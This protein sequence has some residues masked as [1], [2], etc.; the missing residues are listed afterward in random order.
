MFYKGLHWLL[1]IKQ[2]FTRFGKC[3]H[4]Y[5]AINQQIFSLQFSRPGGGHWDVVNGDNCDTEFLQFVISIFG[6]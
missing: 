6:W 1:K 4:N 2:I 5:D 3:I